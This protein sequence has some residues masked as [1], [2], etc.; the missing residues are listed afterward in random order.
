MFVIARRAELFNVKFPL[1][2]SNFSPVNY[3][4]FYKRNCAKSIQLISISPFAL[5]KER[6]KLALPK[7]QTYIANTCAVYETKM[8]EKKVKTVNYVT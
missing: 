1:S 3:V 2:N 4:T 6:F 7:K 5:N 8:C